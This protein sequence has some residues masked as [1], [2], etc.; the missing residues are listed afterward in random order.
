MGFLWNPDFTRLTD[1][2]V[3]RSADM[4]HVVMS[5]TL[6]NARLEVQARVPWTI[7]ER[8]A[9][10]YEAWYGTAAGRRADQAERTLL[11]WLLA[12]FPGAHSVLE[13]GCGTGHFTAWLATQRLRAVG[14]ERAPAMLVTM[15]RRFPEL[16]AILGDAH[17]LP[18]RAGAVDV[19]VFVT[20]LEFLEEPAQARRPLL[21]QAH[22][23]SIRSLRALVRRAAGKRL[24][25]VR[26]ASTLFPDGL[27]RRRARIPVGNII[28][29]SAVLAAPSTAVSSGP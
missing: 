22:D 29:L 17:Q 15:R 25:G 11:R 27:W 12:G 23:Y 18:L 20:A 9:G 16:P 21:S 7:F 3:W 13:V 10:H 5:V 1:A 19:V 24:H 14:L 4:G 2:K 8:A 28:G 26:W 6:S